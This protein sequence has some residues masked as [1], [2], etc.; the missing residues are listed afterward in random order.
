M[1][2]NLEL[3]AA[4]VWAGGAAQPAPGGGATA[5]GR[6]VFGAVLVLTLSDILNWMPATIRI[7]AIV[8]TPAPHDSG[9]LAG[10]AARERDGGAAVLGDLRASPTDQNKVVMGDAAAG[11]QVGA[12]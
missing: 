10:A 7:P 1:G 6:A 2:K 4:A 11:G 8:V 5:V 3:R 12:H 9:I